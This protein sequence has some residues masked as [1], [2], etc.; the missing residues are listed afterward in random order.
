MFVKLNLPNSSIFSL[1]K[2]HILGKSLKN[3][4]SVVHISLDFLFFFCTMENI[5]E[6]KQQSVTV[7]QLNIQKENQEGRLI[8]GKTQNYL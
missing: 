3:V 4:M 1:T 7:V 5:Q 6:R 8:Q 2:E